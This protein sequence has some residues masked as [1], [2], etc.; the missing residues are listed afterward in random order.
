M[1]QSD[2]QGEE[3]MIERETAVVES[4]CGGRR[5]VYTGVSPDGETRDCA[6]CMESVRINPDEG[7]V[8]HFD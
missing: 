2:F 7:T 3:Q 1:S 5:T 6:R 4:E 8:T